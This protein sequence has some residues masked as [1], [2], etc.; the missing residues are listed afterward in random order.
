MCCGKAI[1]SGRRYFVNLP[2][3]FHVP[4]KIVV[5]TAVF[6]CLKRVLIQFS[7]AIEKKDLDS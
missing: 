2:S 4:D 7:P 5:I 1:H 6:M 3:F